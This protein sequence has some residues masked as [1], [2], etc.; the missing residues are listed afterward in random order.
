MNGPWFLLGIFFFFSVVDQ[1]NFIVICALCGL[2]PP[3]PIR[4]YENWFGLLEKEVVP[5]QWLVRHGLD[6]SLH[7]SSTRK[8]FKITY[9]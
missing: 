9:F 5:R 2:Y 3:N 7:H 8:L 1:S 6:S 4:S